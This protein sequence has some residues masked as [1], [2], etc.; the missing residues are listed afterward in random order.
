MQVVALPS[1]SGCLGMPLPVS[2]DAA[3]GGADADAAV[4]HAYCRVSGAVARAG[5]QRQCALAW[6]DLPAAVPAA[7]SHV[8][9]LTHWSKFLQGQFEALP[10]QG[11]R[12][13]LLDSGA[14]TMALELRQTASA[15]QVRFFDP[16]R[17]TVCLQLR[18]AT[19]QA[20]PQWPFTRL[21]ARAG[22]LSKYFGAGQHTDSARFLQVLPVP[23]GPAPAA[24]GQLLA[25]LSEQLQPVCLAVLL[26]HGWRRTL[27]ALVQH[28]AFLALPAHARMHLL[29]A[30]DGHGN[31][32]LWWAMAAGHTATVQ[33]WLAALAAQHELPL[34]RRTE[35]L[36]ARQRSG[37]AGWCAALR[38]GHGA[39]LAV[40]LAGVAAA[41][42]GG[43]RLLALLQADP[44]DPG[45]ALRLALQSGQASVVT[46]WVT[47]V[48]NAS[49]L[50]WDA[51]RSLLH[52]AAAARASV[53]EHAASGLVH[54][55]LLAW[56]TAV[57]Q[58]SGLSWRQ[59]I[60]LLTVDAQHAPRLHRLLQPV[61]RRLRPRAPARPSALASAMA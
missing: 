24:P 58:A 59:K 17:P 40:W 61:L 15:Q 22:R 31:A 39:T 32:G 51:K 19:T 4:Q 10:A 54:E 50:D 9:S 34:A 38:Y 18:A 13:F 23:D 60:T 42:L 53:V 33:A 16:A 57:E 28:T 26:R 49:E 46:V 14:H 36:A 41:R 29:A 11:V 3:S 30:Q 27:T 55:V 48:A 2:P 56:L 8:L 37:E 52:G 6:L 12:R 44:A 20:W 5:T 47:A 35:L 25:S 7:P 21:I 43:P 45:G 1:P